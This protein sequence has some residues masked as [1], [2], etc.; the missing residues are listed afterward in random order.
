[1]NL[2][3]VL[4]IYIDF[5]MSVWTDRKLFQFIWQQLM[6]CQFFVHW[7][8]NFYWDKVRER[9]FFLS[10]GWSQTGS[11]HNI[12]WLG[13]AIIWRWIAFFCSF[14]CNSIKVYTI[15]I[16]SH[17]NHEHA[18]ILLAILWNYEYATLLIFRCQCGEKML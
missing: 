9:F 18:L 11:M 15:Y 1:M 17:F 7:I 10:I 14:F 16:C 13:T 3:A 5:F 4:S 8:S 2:I 12:L 6:N